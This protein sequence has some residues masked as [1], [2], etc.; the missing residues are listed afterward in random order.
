[1]V[2]SIPFNP[3]NTINA[4]GSFGVTWNGAIQG[5][6]MPDPAYRYNLR[7]GLLSQSETIPMWGGVG[8]SET[9]PTPQG[10]P[11]I[12]PS[13]VLGGTISR[14]TNISLVGAAASL[15]GFSVFD[16]AYGMIAT[17]QSQVS[18]AA[19]GMQVMLYALGSGARIWVLMAPGLT[20]LQGA[21]ITKQV[22][23]DFV[24]QQLVPY[25]PAYG[26]ATISG[27][28][29]ASTSGGQ[30]TFTVN[31]DYT[32]LLVAGDVITVSGVVNTGGTSTSAFNG[33]FVV[34][35][36][37]DATHLVVTQL[38][39]A[40]PGTYASGGSIAAGGGALPVQILK[41]EVGNSMVVAYDPITGFA[42]WNRAGS[43][44]LI[45]I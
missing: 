37:T 42:S 13:E 9:V 15:T 3:N 33:Q 39:A 38:A 2:A 29:W 32:A 7:S 16:Q 36:V 14:A 21:I 30:T 4:P 1:M 19:S 17:P 31:V 20:T 6:A 34:A 43:C 44:A 10:S 41:T 12:T 27:A 40:S 25:A 24:N 23:W 8:I 35:S 22:S 28:S 26:S 18:L 45:K 11:P 5:T